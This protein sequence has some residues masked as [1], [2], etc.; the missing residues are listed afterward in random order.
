MAR[1]KNTRMADLKVGILV[2]SS[3]AGLILL[4]LAVSGDISLF[5]DRIRVT[6]TLPQA[7]GLKQ[8]DEVRLAGVPVGVV[9]R[10][11]FDQ[12]PE[13]T[14]AK[15]SVIVTMLIDRKKAQDRIRSDSRVVL[16]SVGLLGG[17]Y[18]NILPGTLQGEV[19]REG[20]RIR[21]LKEQSI[22]D[23]VEGSDDV[24][25]GFQ[26]LTD[27]LNQITETINNGKGTIGKFINDDAFYV[28]LNN[29]NLEAQE[30][31]RRIREGNGTAGRLIND[32]R[33]YNDLTATVNSLQAVVDQIRT[34]P[35]TVPRLLRE[36]EIYNSLNAATA[37]LNATGERIDR[38][39]AQIE[40]GPG[41]AHGLLYDDKIQQ[42]ATAAVAS[43]RSITERLERSEGTAGKLLHDDA[44]YNN[45]NQLTSE[46]VKLLYD[47]RQNPKKYL[48]IKVTLF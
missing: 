14:N 20:D 33:L 7:E 38:I 45:L 2:L 23:V 37:R 1:Q 30:L 8:G 24:L 28:N 17:Q 21:G 29:T 26:Q 42:D 13:D 47:F 9:D 39:V 10:I 25:E 43:L 4:I 44:L 3:I 46:S 5:S 40:T 34:G 35:G 41:T 16:R 27:K 32:P 15:S 22:Q 19:V 11:D 12:I 31:I 18:L 48:S 36:D 6:T